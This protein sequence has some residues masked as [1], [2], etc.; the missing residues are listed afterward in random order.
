MKTIFVLSNGR[1]GTKFLSEL[2]RINAINCVSKHEPFPDM[3]GRPI[4]WYHEKEYQKIKKL[5]LIK[6]KRL[7]RI[8]KDFY[9]ESNHA[10]LKSFSDIAIE[11]FPDMKLLHLVRNPLK[12]VRSMLNKYYWDNGFYGKLLRPFRRHY[13]GNNGHS[14][15]RWILTGKEQIFKDIELVSLTIYQKYALEWIEV[16]NRAINFLNKYNKHDDCYIL[17]TPEDLNKKNVLEELFKF[18][19]III[20]EK[21]VI[22][23][24]KKNQN[25]FPTI[26]SDQDKIEFQ[27]VVNA[28]PEKYLKIFH[29]KPYTNYKWSKLLV[30][31]NFNI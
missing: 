11:Y 30:K 17:H 2:F 23:R 20:K 4:Y 25:Y 31:K 26:I 21:K 18:L 15:F 9:L 7:N 16:E 24:G 6:K 5:F 19:G 28:L 29:N 3:F 12:T 1:S 10:F 22:I 27:D 14:Y 8:K 13:K